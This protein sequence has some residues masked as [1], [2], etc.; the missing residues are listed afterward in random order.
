[1]GNGKAPG[2]DGLPVEFYKTFWDVLGIDLYSVLLQCIDDGILPHSCRRSVITL[3]P[4]DG[5]NGLLKN[6]RPVSLLC[7]DLKIFTKSLSL[8]IGFGKCFISFIKLL[9][10]CVYCVIKINNCF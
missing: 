6:W 4:K 8:R 1:M 3:L 5:D 7:T 10:K 2:I 9:Y